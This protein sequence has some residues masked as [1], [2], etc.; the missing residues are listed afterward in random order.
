MRQTITRFF[1]LLCGLML[2]FC[3]LAP[4]AAQQQNNN[5]NPPDYIVPPKKIMLPDPR[6]LPKRSDKKTRDRTHQTLQKYNDTQKSGAVNSARQFRG[7]RD[8]YPQHPWI[9][10]TGRNPLHA[11]ADWYKDSL[12][13]AHFP[14][15][16]EVANSFPTDAD[17]HLRGEISNNPLTSMVDLIDECLEPV[18]IWPWSWRCQPGSFRPSNDDFPQIK[19]NCPVQRNMG[20]IFGAWWP[21]F[22]I[23]VNGYGIAAINPIAHS[24]PDLLRKALT[25]V[26]KSTF[27]PVAISALRTLYGNTP[28]AG[29]PGELRDD[30]HIGNTQWSG[31]L[32]GDQT[33][34]NEAHI[35]ET[36]IDDEA[37]E[38]RDPDKYTIG[39]AYEYNSKLNLC[40]PYP[41]VYNGYKHDDSKYCAYT[42]LEKKGPEIS[43]FTEEMPFHSYWTLPDLSIFADDDLYLASVPKHIPGSIDNMTIDKELAPAHY[44]RTSS[45]AS[46]RAKK[47]EDP[48]QDLV[49]AV[50]VVPR[51]TDELEK[52]CYKGGGQLYPLTGKLMGHFNPFTSAG[53]LA[54]RA[55]ELGSQNKFPF[56]LA[57][58]GGRADRTLFFDDK[59]DKLQMVYPRATSCFRM[60]DI[61]ETNRSKFPLA[62]ETP[63]QL[64]SVRYVYW[65]YKMFDVCEWTAAMREETLHFG[66]GGGCEIYDDTWVPL[67]RHDVPAGRG[68]KQEQQ[69][70]SVFGSPNW[71]PIPP[72]DP[73]FLYAE[74]LLQLYPWMF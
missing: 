34:Q 12:Y 38:K 49:T 67:D 36:V 61:D 42:V 6:F 7:P 41:W 2:P 51:K 50:G 40:F 39:W 18:I 29:I 64:G 60:N 54:R 71:Y 55:I 14:F 37:S 1:T 21:E 11:Y 63:G 46:Y 25:R 24:R 23:E 33:Y 15:A 45:C 70:P 68:D 27:D 32:P 20:Y 59:V 56:N 9:K 19:S 35:Y 74:S 16:E 17:D 44:A 52:I 8:R 4:A 10:D 66:F 13:A 53:F 57:R 48:F 26:K 69:E 31:M 73:V 65:N 72:Y 47:W 43:M 3:V 28:D 22:E 58:I 30:P 5:G 62:L